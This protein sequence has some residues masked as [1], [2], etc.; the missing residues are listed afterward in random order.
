M[1]QDMQ[2]RWVLN[3]NAEDDIIDLIPDHDAALCKV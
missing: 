1:N 3:K 2:Q